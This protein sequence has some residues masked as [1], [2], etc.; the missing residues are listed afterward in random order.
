MH[1]TIVTPSTMKTNGK[2]NC[3]FFTQ[4]DAKYPQ[5]SYVR[6]PQWTSTHQRTMKEE[7]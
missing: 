3:M 5:Q 1:L 7:W 6:G 4:Q 2:I